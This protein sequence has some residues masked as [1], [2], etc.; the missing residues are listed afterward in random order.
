MEPTEYQKKA[1]RSQT[2]LTKSEFN[3]QDPLSAYCIPALAIGSEEVVPNYGVSEFDQGTV[4]FFCGIIGL[5]VGIILM[6]FIFPLMRFVSPEFYGSLLYLLL[7]IGLS[8]Y[9][10]ERVGHLLCQHYYK[11]HR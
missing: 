11:N 9:A 6:A 3:T 8:W 5:A 4:A 2:A 1:E 10:G 7:S